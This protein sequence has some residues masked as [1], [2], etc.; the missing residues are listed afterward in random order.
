MSESIVMV[1][2]ISAMKIINDD[3]AVLHMDVE[4]AYQADSALKTKY[5]EISAVEITFPFVTH[6][7]VMSFIHCDVTPHASSCLSATTLC[8][9]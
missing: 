6:Y 4:I 3:I 9:H 7:D 5:N 1:V 8:R 2:I